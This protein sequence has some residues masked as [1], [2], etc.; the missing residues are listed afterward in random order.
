ENA[1]ALASRF[2][3]YAIALT[4][5]P[6]QLAEADIVISSTARREP[7]L[8]RATV[9]EAIAARRRKPMFLVDIAVPRDIEPAVASIEDVVLQQIH[10]LRQVIDKNLRSRREAARQAEAMIEL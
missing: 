4:D 3:G 5:L 10:H 6:K 9:V 7:V 8:D 2:G 1:Q